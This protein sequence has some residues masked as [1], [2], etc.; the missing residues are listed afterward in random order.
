MRIGIKMMGL[1]IKV[2]VFLSLAITAVIGMRF[3]NPIFAPIIILT[4]LIL[5]IF[6]NKVINRKISNMWGGPQLVSIDNYTIYEKGIY[7]KPM[8][9]FYPWSELITVR[10]EQSTLTFVFNDGTEISLSGSII[11]HLQGCPCINRIDSVVGK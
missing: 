4:L 10:N 7:I 5:I 3:V 2:S 8:D 1:I 9:I 11:E 6:L